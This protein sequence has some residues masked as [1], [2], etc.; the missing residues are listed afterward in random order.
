MINM[1]CGQCHGAT[2]NGPR[3]NMGLYNMDF[4]YFSNLVYNHTTA[5]PQYRATIGNPGTN[6]DM[7]N[8]NRARL[9]AGTLRQIYYWARDEIGVRAPIAVQIAKGEA[10]ANGVTYPVTVTNNGMQGRGIVAEGLTVSL[11]IPADTTV[12]A[13]TGT[14]Y[15]GT[16]DG[17]QDQGHGRHVEAAAQRPQGP[18]EAQHHALQAGDRRRQP[19]GRS[20]L[21]QAVAEDR[22][23]RGRGQYRACAALVA[24]EPAG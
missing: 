9:T 2:F 6:L 22:P 15:Q 17:R 13:A 21:D 10:G 18:G 4:E 14:G 1:G 20:P 11:T 7:G 19:Q 5:M 24:W 3:A 8:F 12:V 23:E 16:H